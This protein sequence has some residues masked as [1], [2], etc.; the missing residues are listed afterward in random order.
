[1]TF[2]KDGANFGEDVVIFVN[3]TS[4]TLTFAIS[5]TV[6]ALLGLA[7][8]C[9]KFGEDRAIFVNLTFDLSDLDLC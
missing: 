6:V 7:Y 2:V 5:D 3:L 8:T 4:M 1:V 9:A